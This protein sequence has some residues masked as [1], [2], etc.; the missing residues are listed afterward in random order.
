MG[1]RLGRLQEALLQALLQHK[2]VLLAQRRR[3]RDRLPPVVYLQVVTAQVRQLRQRPALHCRLASGDDTAAC[4]DTTCVACNRCS[5]ACPV[6]GLQSTN[7]ANMVV[8][9]RLV[10]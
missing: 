10:S 1:C 6:A 4:C 5:T 2:L 3:L 9:L 7:C 8:Y